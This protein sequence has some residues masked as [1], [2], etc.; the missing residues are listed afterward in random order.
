MM[1]SHDSSHV[2]FTSLIASIYMHGKTA[3][4]PGKTIGPDGKPLFLIYG[5]HSAPFQHAKCY[6][7]S[8]LVGGGIGCTPMASFIK[9]YIFNLQHMKNMLPLNCYMCWMVR[10]DLLDS[11]RWFMRVLKECDD[12]LHIIKDKGHVGIQ[13]YVT[14]LPKTTNVEDDL[15][16][17]AVNDDFSN[18]GRHLSIRSNDTDGACG[19]TELDVYRALKTPTKGQIVKLG[20]L[21][22]HFERP[23][24]DNIFRD[25][26]TTHIGA[27]FGVNV[28]A[29]P[30]ISDDL[31]KVC[32]KF[33]SADNNYIINLHSE[34]F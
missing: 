23:K 24:W 18:W 25:I 29:N 1:M 22:I 12:E 5:P 20:F 4:V 7:V 15:L 32:T 2:E 28:C 17:L 27:P 31:K 9:E 8:L 26:T 11:F 30:A 6:D 14:S 21:S 3:S 19:Y 16:E 10:Y 33:S 34:V 13:I